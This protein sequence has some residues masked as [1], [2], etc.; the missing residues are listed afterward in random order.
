MGE[1]GGLGLLGE[2]LRPLEGLLG[3]GIC[4]FGDMVESPDKI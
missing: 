4:F 3:V 1:V 2:A